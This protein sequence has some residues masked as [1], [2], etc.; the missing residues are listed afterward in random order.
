MIVFSCTVLIVTVTLC[1]AIEGK[2]IVVVAVD[3]A[4][5]VVSLRK[6][7]KQ[8]EYLSKNIKPLK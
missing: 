2:L 4:E 3:C 7:L 8:E 6:E 5:K 1:I